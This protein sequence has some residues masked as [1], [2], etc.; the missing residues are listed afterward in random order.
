VTINLNP[1]AV[2]DAVAES[3]RAE[4]EDKARA[5]LGGGEYFTAAELEQFTGTKAA[6][7]RYWASV[8]EG[9]QNLLLGKRR[10][11]PRAAVIRWLVEQE[12]KPDPTW[13]EAG[14]GSSD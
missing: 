11:W 4:L 10:V 2:A 7:W 13:G 1:S 14:R 12:L 3:R 9:P 6:T 8:H 5:A